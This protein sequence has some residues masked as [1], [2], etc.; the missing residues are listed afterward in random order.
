M[1]W[2]SVYTEF[3]KGETLSDLWFKICDLWSVSTDFIFLNDD[4]QS[5]SA[6]FWMCEL[7]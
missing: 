3:A 5:M 2:I 1:V 4:L 7:W 6:D